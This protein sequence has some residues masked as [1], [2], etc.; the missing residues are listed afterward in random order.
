MNVIDS[1][2]REYLSCDNVAVESADP[3]IMTQARE[4]LLL[5]ATL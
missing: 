1:I 5:I 2:R 4:V 3:M